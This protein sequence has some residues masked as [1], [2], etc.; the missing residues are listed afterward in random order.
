MFLGK[1]KGNSIYDSEGGCSPL[2]AMKGFSY[3][4]WRWEKKKQLFM[5]E[6][7]CY[8]EVMKG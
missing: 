5:K 2:A 3:L 4:D 8:H 1:L 7:E 6:G